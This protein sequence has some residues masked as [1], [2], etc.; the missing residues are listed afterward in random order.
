[1]RRGPAVKSAGATVIQVPQRCVLAQQSRKQ[2][3]GH[4]RIRVKLVG[5]A[6]HV[7][8]YYTVTQAGK[9]EVS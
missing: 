7:L 2:L 9:D 8:I 6:L 1:M 3:S 4:S 5:T